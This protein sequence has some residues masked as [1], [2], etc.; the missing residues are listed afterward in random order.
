MKIRRRSMLAS[1]GVAMLALALTASSTLA[2]T[3]GST[4]TI[5]GPDVA[6]A[7]PSGFV[8]SGSRLFSAYRVLDGDGRHIEFR[9]SA[10]GGATFSDPVEISRPEAV[11]SYQAALAYSGGV[12]H[13]AWVEGTEAQTPE[14]G[15]YRRST[16][17]G[18]TWSDPI[19][20]TPT[21]VESVTSPR[22]FA[23]GSRVFFTYTDGVTGQIWIKRSTDGGVTFATRK[24][25]ATT[26]RRGFAGS[27]VRDAR[28]TMAFGTGVIYVVYRSSDH[29]VRL[30]RSTDAGGSW[31][32]SVS[33][34]S[35][36]YSDPTIAATGESAV[37]AYSYF[38]G[39]TNEYAAIRRTS[40]R[41]STW[42]ARRRVSS[43]TSAP[44]TDAFVIRADGRWRIT[45]LRCSSSACDLS[46]LWYR[47][48]RDGVTWSTAQRFTASRAVMRQI[49]LGYTSSTKQVW[50]GWLAGA[51]P[52]ASDFTI[53]ARGGG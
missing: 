14:R 48:S 51:D 39:T 40:N 35:R 37:I 4:T 50:A 49:G 10:D 20:L 29:G 18:V 41:G 16:D 8:A 24:A 15:F 26:T 52:A 46:A 32:P 31:K 36:V 27:E 5:S 1:I 38:D 7:W 22:V 13:V 11:S 21:A 23:S 42:G 47:S 28:A 2:L 3:W 30:R 17:G 33:V 43:G 34:S 44:A 9:R 25:V 45:Y 6:N 19:A 12:L 53:Y